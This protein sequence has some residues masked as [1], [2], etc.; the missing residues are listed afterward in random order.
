MTVWIVWA[1]GRLVTGG[2]LLPRIPAA[3]PW[4]HIVQSWGVERGGLW[5]LQCG[6]CS[7][8]DTGY[9]YWYWSILHRPGHSLT[10]HW[11]WVK[12]RITHMIQLQSVSSSTVN[13]NSNECMWHVTSIRFLFARF[14][15]V[16]L[17]WIVRKHWTLTPYCLQK[18][19]ERVQVWS[20]LMI[21]SPM[22]CRWWQ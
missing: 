8:Q 20:N 3:F 5:R 10:K 6:M 14:T 17:Q 4:A 12:W 18:Y 22:Q 21:I 15:T 9:Q 11:L 2:H 16:T 13:G 7:V 1:T 19:D